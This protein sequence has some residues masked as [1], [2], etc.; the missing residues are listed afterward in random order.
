MSCCQLAADDRRSQFDAVFWRG[1]VL[2][3]LQLRDE[4]TTHRETEARLK[5]VEQANAAVRA[6]LSQ[7]RHTV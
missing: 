2:W 6:E 4:Q 1:S 3:R 7:A 5:D